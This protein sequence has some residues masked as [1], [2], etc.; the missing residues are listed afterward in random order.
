VLL[1]GRCARGTWYVY[2]KGL[3]GQRWE[4]SVTDSASMAGMCSMH[5]AVQTCCSCKQV[6]STTGVRCKGAELRR[7]LAGNAGACVCCVCRNRKQLH[8]PAVCSLAQDGKPVQQRSGGT[9]NTWRSGDDGRTVAE[10]LQ[11]QF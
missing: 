9:L 1:V 6:C 4:V 7:N 5:A 2:M 8:G 3:Q 10:R 11:V